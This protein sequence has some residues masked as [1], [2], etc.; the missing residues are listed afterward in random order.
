MYAL[1]TKE[2]LQYIYTMNTDAP[3]QRS[4]IHQTIVYGVGNTTDAGPIAML[5]TTQAQ[6]FLKQGQVV[7][8]MRAKLEEALR[9][10]GGDVFVVLVQ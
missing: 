5:T 2:I 1:C 6:E 7:A 10:L 3:K 8:G 4:L 9:A